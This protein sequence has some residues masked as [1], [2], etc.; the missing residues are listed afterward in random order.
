MT[1]ITIT[2]AGVE[3]QVGDQ[4]YSVAKCSER[5]SPSATGSRADSAFLGP[6]Q[7]SLTRSL[8]STH[9]QG[10]G[11]RQV[12]L[13]IMLWYYLLTMIFNLLI[14]NT[15]PERTPLSLLQMHKMKH[16]EVKS[17]LTLLNRT[18]SGH[19]NPIM[20]WDNSNPVHFVCFLWL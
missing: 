6:T 16:R 5:G 13:I 12:F 17:C 20:V 7:G 8:E 1:K 2:Y 18:I 19:R 14:F 4:A 15:F 3:N 11:L 9:R 10:K